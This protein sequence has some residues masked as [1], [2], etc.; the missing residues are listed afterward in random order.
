NSF[1]HF[2]Q[3][4]HIAESVTIDVRAHELIKSILSLKQL[5]PRA[6]DAAHLALIQKNSKLPSSILSRIKPIH[7]FLSIAQVVKPN[8]SDIELRKSEPVPIFLHLGDGSKE[9]S[10]LRRCQTR[11]KPTYADF[12][13]FRVI[14]RR[15]VDVDVRGIDLRL[16]GVQRERCEGYRRECKW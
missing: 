4:I 3:S 14:I 2:Q 12:W 9:V 1:Y 6:A 5:K 15:D 10:F 8:R 7:R 13:A 16:R 11:A